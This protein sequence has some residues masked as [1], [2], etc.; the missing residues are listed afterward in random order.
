MSVTG[1]LP[2]FPNAEDGKQIAVYRFTINEI[3]TLY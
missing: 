1:G 3:N 2:L